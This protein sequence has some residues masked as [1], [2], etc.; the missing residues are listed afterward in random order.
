MKIPLHTK[1]RRA[2]RGYLY[3]IISKIVHVGEVQS[4][5]DKSKIN[6][7]VIIRPNYRIG[8]II[9]LTPLINEIKKAMPQA[10]VDVIVGMKLAGEILQGM[11]NVENVQSIPR[12]L[13]LHPIEL[14]RF[15]KDARKEE[16]DV[17]INISS[18]SLSSE[19]VTSL[20]NAKYKAGFETKNFTTLTHAVK[21]EKLYQHSG[22]QTLELLKL[23]DIAL[24]SK[25]TLLDIQL[26]DEEIDNAKEE[27]QRLL[28][29]NS[30]AKNT[31]VI[32]LFRNA[33]FDKKI[34]DAWWQEWFD[35]L[36]KLDKSVVVVDILSPDIV[37]KLNDDVLEYSNKNLRALG[38]FFRACDIYVSAD[39][40]PLHLASASGARV[41]ALFNKTN[42]AV[43]GTLGSKS[44]TVDI[45]GLS[46]KEV[47]SLTEN[48]LLKDHL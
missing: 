33:R 34:P 13:L 21:K 37:T 5:L 12:A 18:G 11:P 7:I 36:K 38:A 2:F 45:N 3:A 24:P 35:S 40:G 29:E 17:A 23:F 25:E 44:K 9:F 30:I 19:I 31:K 8:N 6:K 42:A 26:S 48:F 4:S 15:I 14:Y 32:A 20:V 47:A 28:Q 10:K 22:H 16:Y 41:L 27:L 1:L 39:T 43:Y 46:A